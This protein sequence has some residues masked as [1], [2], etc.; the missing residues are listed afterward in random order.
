MDRSRLAGVKH[1]WACHHP[2][3]MA[4]AWLE[5]KQPTKTAIRSSHPGFLT[6]QLYYTCISVSRVG[7]KSGGFSYAAL[8]ISPLM[9]GA[10]T[11]A[12]S[13]QACPV[14]LQPQLG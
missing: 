2:S 6:S 13:T 12:T 10:T 11:D 9:L 1:L 5:N 3:Q 4:V 14:A 8:N 7:T